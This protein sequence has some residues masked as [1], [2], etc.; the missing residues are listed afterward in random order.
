MRCD[1]YVF[2]VTTYSLGVHVFI[3]LTPAL[4]DWFMNLKCTCYE[5]LLFRLRFSF[6]F[7]WEFLHHNAV[8]G[9]KNPHLRVSSETVCDV[10]INARHVLW[11]LHGIITLASLYLGHK[12][13]AELIV[14][15]N[16]V[17]CRISSQVWLPVNDIDSCLHVSCRRCRRAAVFVEDLSGITL[18]HA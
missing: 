3:I 10:A 2:V 12:H 13:C 5:S 16:D 17:L 14:S 7:S 9:E 4:S 15:L 8:G 18:V 6:F 11:Y 1:Y